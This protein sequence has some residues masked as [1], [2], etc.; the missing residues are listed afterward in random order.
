MITSP[1]SLVRQQSR[2]KTG[3]LEYTDA[4]NFG[5][6]LRSK[7]LP[8]GA[9]PE[10]KTHT[11]GEFQQGNSPDWRVK[12]SLPKGGAY[13]MSESDS[14]SSEAN[15][16]ILSELTKTDGFVFPYTPQIFITHSAN[17]D[18]LSPTHSNYPFPIYENS[19]V[20]QFTI[21]GDFTAENAAEGRYWIAA[22]HYLRSVT[23]MNYGTGAGRGNPPPVVKLNGYGDF[24]FKD[25]PV[26]IEQYQLT[27]PQEVDYIKVPI[28][29][30]GSW[31]PTQSN[32]AISVHVA[33][34]RD[35]VNKFSLSKFVNGDYITS[36][37]SPGFI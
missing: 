18:K 13:K 24:I 9:N 7:S 6:N 3:I 4:E 10:K 1:T 17:Y 37:D 25:V 19:Q 30:T 8:V 31:V 2:P 20:D 32:I 36:S 26:V 12:L 35:K 29:K 28:G 16:H 23:K 11:E 34:S 15:P 22:N 5:R 27:L 21:T 33:Y 14:L